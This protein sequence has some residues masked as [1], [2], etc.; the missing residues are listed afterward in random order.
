MV[1]LRLLLICG[2]HEAGV[3]SFHVLQK[4]FL[5]FLLFNEFIVLLVLFLVLNLQGL[6]VL[7]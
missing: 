6:E 1:E 2:G 3:L 4:L 5:L 7:T